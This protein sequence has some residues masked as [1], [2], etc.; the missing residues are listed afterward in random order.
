MRFKFYLILIIGL[1]YS[2][3]VDA[4]EDKRLKGK[5]IDISYYTY[6]GIIDTLY[7]NYFISAG[8]FGG[9]NEGLLLF[10][11]SNGIIKAKSVKYNSSSY[12]IPLEVDTIINFYEMNKNSYTIIKPEWVL[13]KGQFKY[14]AKILDEIKTRPL[15]ENV[16][17]NASDHYAILA[18]N[19]SYVFIDR[20]GDWNKYLEIK[21]ILGIEQQPKK[22]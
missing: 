2:Q 4:Q 7:L 12:G 16:F 20:T 8:E 5:A 10:V 9:S 17:S 19:E 14:I 22:L 18:K 13:S 11:D 15:E 3:S 1:F 6:Q 21:E